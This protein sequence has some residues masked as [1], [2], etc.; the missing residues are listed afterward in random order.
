MTMNVAPPPAPVALSL[1]SPALSPVTLA[2]SFISPAPPLE[3]V[4]L[5]S[6]PSTL[7]PVLPTA[8]P[9]VALASDCMCVYLFL[10]FN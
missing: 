9:R 2:P 3:S 4:A 5:L 6:T 8:L 10:F 7:P 1:A